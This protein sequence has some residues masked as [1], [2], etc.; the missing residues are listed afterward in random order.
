[1]QVT[2]LGCGY[3][4]GVPVIG[5][6]CKVC[7]SEIE[8][9]KRGRCSILLEDEKK[10]LLID[11][12]PDLRAQLLREKVKN[13]DASLLTHAHADHMH[14]VDDLKV[15]SH[16]NELPL[17]VYGD[18]ETL[19]ELSHRFSYMFQS[20]QGGEKHNP[21]RLEAKE[22]AP[23]GKA[24]IAGFELELFQ[25]DHG[26]MY[27]LGFKI[28]DFA[29][30]NDVK[31]IPA[32]TEEYLYNLETLVIDCVDYYDTRAH[33]GLS[34]VLAWI[35]KFKPAKVYLTNMGHNIDYYEIQKELPSNVSP[36]YDGMKI[37][38]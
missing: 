29:Y 15:F 16:N 23:R 35:E 11:F 9:N 34:T 33:S 3:S 14:G 38:V 17:E 20:W 2:I 10:N 8:L 12:G 18:V 36:A 24:N 27:S 13:I 4:I 1:M 28:N 5:C 6:D 26:F 37:N 25:L 32:E 22:V 30:V 19:K 7:S 21:P 31:R